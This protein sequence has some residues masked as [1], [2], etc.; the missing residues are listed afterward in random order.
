M[1]ERACADSMEDFFNELG[2]DSYLYTKL[3]KY[4]KGKVV[5]DVACGTGLGTKIIS[6]TAKKVYGVDLSKKVIKRNME[7]LGNA[8]CIFISADMLQLP[9][10]N[11]FFDVVVS[12]ETIEHTIYTDKFL[13]EIQRVLKPQGLLLLSTPNNGYAHRIKKKFSKWEYHILEFSKAELDEKIIKRFKII[14]FYGKNKK[15]ILEKDI[16]Q[17]KSAFVPDWKL[18]I[19]FRVIPVIKRILP[20]GIKKQYRAY[21]STAS[22]INE[23]YLTQNEKGLRSCLNFFVVAKKN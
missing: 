6:E 5:L 4:I 8:K 14:K 2:A 18:F 1:S 10:N 12:F 16:L 17:K 11:N 19:I 3:K 21:S 23:F 15:G 13:D 9:F 20:Q 7:S 22:N